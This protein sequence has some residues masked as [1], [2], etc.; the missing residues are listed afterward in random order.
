[1]ELDSNLLVTALVI[2]LAFLSMRYIP[3]IMAGV[4]F[5]PVDEL[6]GKMDAGEDLVVIDVRTNS[7]FAEGRV[8]GSVNLPLGDI[9][10]KLNQLGGA[11]D[12]YKTHPVYAIC[13]TDNR[14]ANAARA[15]KKAGFANLKVVSGGVSAWKRKSYPVEK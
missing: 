14:S 10:A 5:V 6:K 9:S 3:R 15:L 13:R 8:P 2:A 11:L 7:E 12:D 1:M 4:P